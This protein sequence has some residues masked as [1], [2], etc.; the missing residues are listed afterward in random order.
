MI[1]EETNVLESPY[2][3]VTLSQVTG[4]PMLDL[5]Y[6]CCDMRPYFEYKNNNNYYYTN[7]HPTNI[8]SQIINVYQK[9]KII[10]DRV[11]WDSMK[12][13][14]TTTS[15][16]NNS[17]VYDGTTY[18][19]TGNVINIRGFFIN[20][21]SLVK[22]IS[23]NIISELNKEYI[24][25]NTSQERKEYG[26]EFKG[27]DSQND[28]GIIYGLKA[29]TNTWNNLHNCAWAYVGLPNPSKGDWF[30]MLDFNGYNPKAK[31]SIEG[32]SE[33][34]LNIKKIYTSDT[35][36][37]EISWFENGVDNTNID[38]LK[39]INVTG[40][41]LKRYYPCILISEGD[42]SLNDNLKTT[43][44]RA[45]INKDT[46]TP[47]SLYYKNSIGEE[48]ISR[49]FKCPKFNDS[50]T[51]LIINN[52]T[53]KGRATITIFLAD[54]DGLGN[55]N[56]NGQFDGNEIKNDWFLLG[57]EIGDSVVYNNGISLPNIAGIEVDTAYT[58]IDFSYAYISLVT[59]DN[60]NKTINCI[61]SFDN[62]VAT[63][64]EYIVTNIYIQKIYDPAIGV[65]SGEI[66]YTNI[67]KS[68]IGGHINDLL[69]GVELSFFNKDSGFAV[70]FISG[71]KYKYKFEVSGKWSSGTDSGLQYIS[72]IEGEITIS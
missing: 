1:N 3:L 71:E 17:I 11:E 24:N 13:I 59:Y 25:P 53:G 61:L 56:G 14:G 5:G 58:R 22:P 4:N 62:R 37:L 28:L 36:P 46:D 26:G 63:P 19:F 31:P 50:I 23:S 68:Y 33:E 30:R 41:D 47:T 42:I 48:T 57:N 16:I 15:T 66:Q 64:R 34:L 39:C 20:K 10:R 12:Y 29:G 49:D 18:V 51:N 9:N 43:W 54:L 60:N 67:E 8:S 2:N 65:V 70:N 21:W 40:E 27:S 6:Q 55:L 7:I 45:L 44:C 52:R 72:S 38:I 35:I 69:S 32:Y